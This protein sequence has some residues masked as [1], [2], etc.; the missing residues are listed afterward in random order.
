MQLNMIYP[1][2]YNYSVN[3]I[4]LFL[5]LG[6][7]IRKPL[8][9]ICQETLPCHI[10]GRCAKLIKLESYS[11]LINQSN[12]ESSWSSFALTRLGVFYWFGKVIC[13]LKYPAY[14]GGLAYTPREAVIR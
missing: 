5:P 2:I 10:E 13:L 6:E 7:E 8:I 3:T 1:L 12:I 11:C 14:H 4:F 9:S